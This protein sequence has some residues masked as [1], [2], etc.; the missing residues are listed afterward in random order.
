LIG[1]GPPT[2]PVIAPG[3]WPA[4]YSQP[5]QNVPPL[6]N[7]T[8]RNRSPLLLSPRLTACGVMQPADHA[9]LAFHHKPR[10]SDPPRP[11]DLVRPA[12]MATRSLSSSRRRP[13]RE[14]VGDQASARRPQ[15]GL[16]SCLCPGSGDLPAP[17][18]LLVPVLCKA[19][20]RRAAKRFCVEPGRD[21]SARPGACSIARAPVSGRLL[22]ARIR[23]SAFEDRPLRCR[24]L[25][26]VA[27]GLARTLRKV[28]RR[29]ADH[30]LC[31]RTAFAG[32]AGSATTR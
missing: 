10:R 2:G 12:A 9:R 14:R 21:S 6:R 31:D 3:S 24:S 1:A 13:A 27:L 8:P 20:H 15:R 22:P 25:V 29:W 11:T 16:S 17:E 4:S 5:R 30:R 32:T 26:L 7:A 28:W 18:C 23:R 19:R